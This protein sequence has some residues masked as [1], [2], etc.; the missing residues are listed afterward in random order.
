MACIALAM[1][2]PKAACADSLSSI[3]SGLQI[4]GDLL[5]PDE[6][7][8]T[9]GTGPRFSPDYLGSNDYQVEADFVFLVRVRN[10]LTLDNDGVAINLL[11]LRDLQIGPVLKISGGRNEAAN[12]ALNGLG[13]IGAAFELGAFAKIVIAGKYVARIRYRHAVASGHRG[14]LADA[15]LSTLI[16]E[17]GAGDFSIALGFRGTWA[18]KG[19]AQRF[20][21]INAE[22]SIVSGIEEYPIGS[23][24]RDIRLNTGARW[25]F[26]R[27][28]SLNGYAEYSHL[29]GQVA[30]SPIVDGL[31][32]PGQFSAGA[33]VTHTFV[34]E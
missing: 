33:N 24:V 32:S 26:A 22:Q 10:I 34:F 20:F 16:Y 12:P 17:N 27:N 1:L 3:Y 15:S 14:G 6:T 9:F 19:Y 7:Q 29:V 11:G 30:N 31:G 25:V 4:F 21:G 5:F 18:D 8:I 13:D 23:S 2:M 28:W